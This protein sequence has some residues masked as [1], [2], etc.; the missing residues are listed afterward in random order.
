MLLS[1]CFVALLFG[2]V[3]LQEVSDVLVAVRVLDVVRV[4]E[5]RAGHGDDLRG[6][7]VGE[8]QLA[9]QPGDVFAGVFLE[10]NVVGLRV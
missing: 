8:P 10:S 5:G 1:L 2:D 3:A 7:L 4:E 9:I 6:A